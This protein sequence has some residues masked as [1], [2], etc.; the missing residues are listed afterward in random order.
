MPL[1]AAGLRAEYPVTW[2]QINRPAAER[3]CVG[4]AALFHQILLR[5]HHIALEAAALAFAGNRADPF[6]R[7]RLGLGKLA[8]VFDVIPHAVSDLPQLPL[9]FFAVV[10]RVKHAAPFEP[11]EAAPGVGELDVA[12]ARNLGDVAQ[13]KT[14]RRE[15][16][17]AAR[18][19]RVKINCVAEQFVAGFFR[20]EPFAEFGTRFRSDAK[21]RACQK[22]NN[23]VAARVHENGRGD[24]VSGGVLRAERADGFDGV[25]VRFFQA[26]NRRVQQQREVRLVDNHFEDDGV[27]NERIAFGIAERIFDQHFI[28]H[29]ALARPAVVVAHV[30]GRAENPEP[31]FARR[32]AAEHGAI[33]H[34]HHLA[35]RPRR[36][37][38]RAHTRQPATDD[39][40]LGRNF[41]P[42]Q[43]ACFTDWCF[44][45]HVCASN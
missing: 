30:R 12:P 38:G 18:V 20:R 36:R 25:R 39:G 37:D 5:D 11:P 16:H 31:H 9:D 8:G 15:L 6:E 13:R 24:F 22:T 21:C 33:L 35:A 10:N 40:D 29:A 3:N 23:A 26:V 1:L 45:F 42:A 44:D 43:F 28:N 2:M 27:E 17:R 32:I 7:E 41:L 4:V 19:L 14:R 34:E